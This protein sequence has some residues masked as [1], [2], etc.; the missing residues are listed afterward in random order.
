M[1]MR[2]GRRLL[3]VTCCLICAGA[4]TG[5]A[6]IVQSLKEQ[7][8]R[9][10]YDDVIED[11]EEW[12]QDEGQDDP[13]SDEAREV[14]LLV[15]EAYLH[16]A[17]RQDTVQ[18]Y[19]QFKI[20]FSTRE[21][22]A[23]IRARATAH[24][25]KAYYRDRV[26]AM[27]SVKAHRKFRK[28][29]PKTTL[30]KESRKAEFTLALG[31]ARRENTIAAYRGY[32]DTYGEWPDA[33][34]ALS[35]AHEREANLAFDQAKELDRPAE[36]RQF[37]EK[38]GAWDEARELIIEAIVLEV[39]AAFKIAEEQNSIEGYRTFRQQYDKAKVASAQVAEARKR[40][41]NLAWVE[42]NKSGTIEGLKVFRKA[43]APW[44]EAREL[45]KRAMAKEVELAWTATRSA[46]TWQ[47]YHDFARDFPADPRALAAESAFYRFRRLSELDRGWPRTEVQHQR[48]LPSGEIELHVDVRDCLGRRVS[49]L[50]RDQFDVLA[51]GAPLHITGFSGLEEDRPVDIVF[52]LD[53]SG[54]MDTERQAVNAAVLQF[55]ETFRFRGRRTRIGLVTFSDQVATRH[56]PSRRAA[57]FRRWIEELPPSSGGAGEDGT[58][59]M[60]TG[61]KMSFARKAERVFIMLTDESLQ[62]NQ[63]G[64]SALKLS[65]GTT[66]ICAKLNRVAKCLGRCKNARCRCRCIMKLGSSEA[67]N[68][69]RCLR[70]QSP[71]R[72]LAGVSW[73]HFHNSASRCGQ[74]V[75][76]GSEA[77]NKLAAVLAKRQM[78]MFFVVPRMDG[79]ETLTG[80]DDLASR[81]F[82]RILHVPQDSTSPADYIRPLMDI[83]DQLSKQYVIRFRPDHPAPRFPGDAVASAG[84]KRDKKRIAALAEAIIRSGSLRVAV[85]RMHVWNGLGTARLKQVKSLIPLPGGQKGCPA[86][87]AATAE[88]NLHVVSPCDTSPR[89]V[90]LGSGEMVDRV[91]SSKDGVLV[92]TSTGRLLSLAEAKGKKLT[93]VKT[94]LK[95]VK[96]VK[97][98]AGGA[99]A[100]A[101]TDEEGKWRFALRGAGE[102]EFGEPQDLP[103]EISGGA[104]PMIFTNTA[105]GADEICLLAKPEQMK[106]TSDGGETWRDKSI[107]GLPPTALQGPVNLVTGADTPRVHLAALADGSVYR[108]VAGS[109]A[110]K[111]SLPASANPRQLVIVHGMKS[112]ICAWQQGSLL[113]SEDM[114]SRWYAMGGKAED[115]D[116]T[117]A[118]HGHELFLIGAKRFHRLDRV[119][120]RELASSNIYFSTNSDMPQDSLFPFLRLVAIHMLADETAQLR[121]EGHADQ[122]GSDTYNQ[123][124]AL[125][126]AKKVAAHVASLGVD[127]ERMVV[128]SFGER[129][130]VRS[131]KRAMDLARNRRV[132]ILLVQRIPA[133][134]WKVDMCAVSR[135]K[136]NSASW[137]QRRM[138]ALQKIMLAEARQAPAEMKRV[139]KKLKWIARK[140]DRILPD[141]ARI[142]DEIRRSRNPQT[143]QSLT[144]RRDSI[145][146][147]LKKITK[148]INTVRMTDAARAGLTADIQAAH[149]RCSAR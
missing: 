99:L 124:L 19:R 51:N 103:L 57:D 121:V 92:I 115:K 129:R 100:V 79:R 108:S 24:E 84:K 33:K 109:P 80:F 67:S 112:S 114:G 5:C 30:L 9:Q 130:P 11:G 63:G 123:R 29:Y 12:L 148:R 85:R 82:G 94:G 117:V 122:R 116:L 133:A 145:A 120:N 52:G 18:A 3:A 8:A 56:R 32:H 27:P 106:C 131:G 69:R 141:L 74:P 17:R 138:V 15:A 54:S 62:M 102:Q 86:F 55:A 72:C 22:F 1:S 93:P 98:G 41:L 75:M 40:E 48:V 95:K 135:E 73:N 101:A 42:A 39:K 77:M 13:N 118:S 66:N 142:T 58:H 35:E 16:K 97:V 144:A 127:K 25:A 10:Q 76:R 107:S 111:V 88:R 6:T 43:Y 26:V 64:R 23:P 146:D 113:C 7:I 104:P 126:R 71:E 137:E 47:A 38:Y 136:G 59:A 36:Y 34:E 105:E 83:A 91:V 147:Q 125:R 139:R 78:R 45:I 37:R 44:P 28:L 81:L 46:D 149:A 61:A 4:L 132:E 134:G 70:R 119:A 110:W 143:R 49:G 87:A 96:A 50:T 60:I 21:I 2:L 31:L 14:A 68:M 140:C 128:L 90:A 65:D 53:L 20:K 89:R